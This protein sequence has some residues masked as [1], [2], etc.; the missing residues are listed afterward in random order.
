V[1]NVRYVVVGETVKSGLL[2][3]Q[4]EFSTKKAAKKSFSAMKKEAW[5]KNGQLFKQTI[6]QTI[7]DEFKKKRKR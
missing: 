4:G 7:L 1:K 3:K 2:F 6:K 5:I